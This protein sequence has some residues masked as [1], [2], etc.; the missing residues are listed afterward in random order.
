MWSNMRFRS[1]YIEERLDR[2][3]C[4]KDWD[5]NF[6]NLP[7]TNLVNWVSDQCLIMLEVKEMCKR[8]NYKRRSFPETTRRICGARTRLAAT[9]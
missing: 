1:N 4:S 6:Q 2:S 7:A 5:K 8:L 9:L 3:L